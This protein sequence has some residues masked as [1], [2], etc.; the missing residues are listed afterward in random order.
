VLV[1]AVLNGLFVFVQEPRVEHA[2]ERLRDLRP[3]R[4]SPR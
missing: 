4:H 1:V 2:A 3:T